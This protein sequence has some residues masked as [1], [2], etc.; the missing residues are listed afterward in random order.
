MIDAA[1]FSLGFNISP[2]KGNHNPGSL[3][4]AYEGKIDKNKDELIKLVQSKID[5]LI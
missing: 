2:I 3:F 4:V 1:V 5:E